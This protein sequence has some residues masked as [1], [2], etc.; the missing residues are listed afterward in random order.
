MAVSADEEE[1]NLDLQVSIFCR[2]N[3]SQNNLKTEI[4]IREDVQLYMCSV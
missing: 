2:T 1:M 4:I 3:V